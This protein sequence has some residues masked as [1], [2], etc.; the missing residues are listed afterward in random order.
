MTQTNK[1]PSLPRMSAVIYGGMIFTGLLLMRFWQNNL[2]KSFAIP[3]D[4]SERLRIIAGGILAA[5]LLLTSSA[6]LESCNES[7]R[8]L[9]DMFIQLIGPSPAWVAVWLAFLS[10]FGEEI[11]FRG[12]LQPTFGLV[13]TSIMFGLAHVGP[14]GKIG[15]WSFWA[16][17][18]GLVLGWTYI[19]TSCL[20]P[21]IMGHFLVNGVSLLALQ[22]Q[23]RQR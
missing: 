13:P 8:R 23:Y 19:E 21:A 4:S 12:A 5:T 3:V 17:G 6:A 9:K 16:T 22:R 2:A 20:W 18:A 14:D 11:L 15:V 7:F 1:A 10:S